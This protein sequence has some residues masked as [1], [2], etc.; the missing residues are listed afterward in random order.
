VKY[1]VL[2]ILLIVLSC[3]T[4]DIVTDRD[5]VKSV[6]IIAIAPFQYSSRSVNLKKEIYEEAEKSL[7]SALFKL[8]YKIIQKY[9]QELSL[10]NKNS[11]GAGISIDDII[12]QYKTSGADAV[13]IGN[14]IVN[15]EIE[16]N[17]FPRRTAIFGNL[18]FREQDDEVRIQTIYRFQIEVK[19]A[20]VTNGAVILTL[21]NRYS[22]AEKDEYLPGYLSLDA[23]R[24]LI[25]KKINDELVELL[26]TGM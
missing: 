16:R 26:N 25:L 23:Y 21:K 20:D 3:T 18:R 9:K 5:A 17:I 22:D 4:A 11:S 12:E 24:A 19:L 1:S 2:L 15:E 6:K 8:N 10:K 13:L 7:S 14:V